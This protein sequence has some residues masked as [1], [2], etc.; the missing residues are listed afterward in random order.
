MAQPSVVNYFNA[1]KR[2]AISDGKS[3]V[4]R[5]VFI[6]DTNSN[7]STTDT[8][9]K[10]LIFNEEINR[11]DHVKSIVVPQEIISNKNVLVDKQTKVILKGRIR[12]KQDGQKNIEQYL[13][14][15]S[16]SSKTNNLNS[17]NS[18]KLVEK[19]NTMGTLTPTEDIPKKPKVCDKELQLQALKDKLLHSKRLKEL[20]LS[21]NRYNEKAEKLDELQNKNIEKN[22]SLE[23]VPSK[24]DVP[25]K[26]VVNKNAMDKIS[27]LS[28]N[29]IKT[30]LSRS[31]K[32]AELKAS[33]AR[34][35]EG[36]KKLEK[37]QQQKAEKKEDTGPAIKSFKSLELEVPL[38]YVKYNTCL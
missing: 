37:I 21:M 36:E 25:S 1:R 8:K 24:E 28:M 9:N 26:V 12:K 23:K 33:I 35:K 22:S 11:N 38:R 29:D 19:V 10:Q 31:A 15:F 16:T 20:K 18:I 17:E 7:H 2:A 6:L 3:I 27:E 13:Q 5:K 34:I 32:L 4:A 30:K 14:A